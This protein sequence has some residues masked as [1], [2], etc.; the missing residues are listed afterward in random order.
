[1]ATKMSFLTDNGLK[2]FW[3]NLRKVLVPVFICNSAGNSPNKDI[4][5]DEEFTMKNYAQMIV[6]FSHANTSLNPVINISQGSLP[7]STDN[8]DDEPYTPDTPGSGVSETSEH[9]PTEGTGEDEGG[10]EEAEEAAEETS[11]SDL[12]YRNQPVYG[13][14]S[15]SKVGY[16]TGFC[17]LIFVNNAWHLV[18][19]EAATQR[20]IFYTEGNDVPYNYNVGDIWLKKKASEYEDETEPTEPD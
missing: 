12:L 9:D 4:R 5:V 6:Y 7:S 1:M 16:L 13:I 10:E 14:N 17:H 19:S 3:N 11:S 18:S 2:L 15:A 20:T 8:E